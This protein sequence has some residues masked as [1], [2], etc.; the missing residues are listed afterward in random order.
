MAVDDILRKIAGDAEGAARRILDDGTRQ[1]D[2]VLGE[3]REEADRLKERMR[4]R[5]H[6]RAEEEKNRIVTLARLSAR[7]RLLDAKQKLI[8]RVFDETRNRILAMDRDE[9]RALI[10]GFLKET[11]E[12]GEEEVI[13][14]EGEERI[15]Q[16]LLD[17]VSR[18]LGKGRGLK[19]SPE[20]RAI[21]G[22][23]VLRT[24]R[25]ETNRALDMIMRGA[26]EKLETEVAGILFGKG[27]D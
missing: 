2:A 1:A 9:Y 16:A 20:R 10:K 13:V 26:R 12:T 18:E 5:A 14:A 21:E 17:E 7:R 23:F 6:Q 3:A 25:I 19:L 11:S 15:D 4:S 22:G 24:G 27:A 8:G